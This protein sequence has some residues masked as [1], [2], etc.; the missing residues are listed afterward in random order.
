MKKQ[1][2]TDNPWLVASMQHIS[3]GVQTCD[4]HD[5]CEKIRNSSDLSWLRR[6]LAYPDNQL[7][8]REAAA[9]RIRVL[10][11]QSPTP[12]RSSTLSLPEAA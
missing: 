2:Q 9:R 12:F 11:R 7:T 3:P 10:T 1:D 5:R 8:V 6:V 4:V